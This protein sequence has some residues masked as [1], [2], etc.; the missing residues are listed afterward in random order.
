MKVTVANRRP[1]TEQ[2][3]GTGGRVWLSFPPDA[4][5]VLR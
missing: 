4:G 2:S 1:L 3:I 5:V